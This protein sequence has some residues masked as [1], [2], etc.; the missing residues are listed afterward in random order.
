[1]SFKICIF[2]RLL[3]ISGDYSIDTSDWVYLKFS[4]MT[5]SLKSAPPPIGYSQMVPLVFQ[6]RNLEALTLLPGSWLLVSFLFLFF[7][8]FFL[9][10][11]CLRQG[12]TA[13]HSIT[14]AGVQWCDLGSLQPLPPGLKQSSCFSLQCSWGHRCMT[15][16]LANFCIFLAEIGFPH[17]TQ[18]VLKLL[19]QV[20]HSPL[21][22][23]VLWLQ[24]WATAPGVDL[25][26]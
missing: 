26:F 25:G 14:Q 20:M 18:A 3:G 1:M 2:S 23:K 15:P 9:F 21:P 7:F 19:A 17:D 12:F 6:I 4:Q 16:H 24:A 11:F 5:F 8:L 13:S 10:F 22:P